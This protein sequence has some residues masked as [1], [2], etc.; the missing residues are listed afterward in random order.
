MNDLRV[1]FG[2]D[3]FPLPEYGCKMDGG[4][5]LA[6]KFLCCFLILVGSD[7]YLNMLF[8][9]LCEQLLDTGVRTT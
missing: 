5:V 3:V 4:K 2:G 6:D 7:G 8:L 9:K 1:R